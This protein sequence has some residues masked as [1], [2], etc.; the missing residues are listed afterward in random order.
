MRV[1]QARAALRTRRR[2]SS[3]TAC[4]A[5]P[6]ASRRALLH[7]DEDDRPP[8]AEHEVELV[9][10][11]T[12]VRIEQAVAADRVVE[13]G[14]ALAAIHAASAVPAYA[15]AL[16]ESRCC[17]HGP[18]LADRRGVTGVMYPTWDAKP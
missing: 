18:V 3:P 14:A 6:K 1:S 5:P 9:A 13:Q 11:R 4:S 16:N 8:S 7:L 2:F 15:F 17:A 10:R 12:G